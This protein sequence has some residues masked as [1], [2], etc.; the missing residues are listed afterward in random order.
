MVLGVEKLLKVENCTQFMMFK[1]MVQKKYH[2]QFQVSIHFLFAV[3]N[4]YLKLFD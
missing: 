1:K 2:P 3:T 4:F